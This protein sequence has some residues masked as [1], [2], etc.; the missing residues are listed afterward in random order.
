MAFH[1]MQQRDS[2]G[3]GPAVQHAR[4]TVLCRQ[5]SCLHLGNSTDAS[6]RLRSSTRAKDL[7]ACNSAL[8]LTRN[9]GVLPK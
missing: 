8:G 5:S 4:K 1:E 3:L 6:A 2:A 9:D 7:A